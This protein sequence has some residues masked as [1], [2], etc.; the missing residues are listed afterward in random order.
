MLRVGKS[1][2]LRSYGGN[3]MKTPDGYYASPTPFRPIGSG[4]ADLIRRLERITAILEERNDPTRHFAKTYCHTNQAVLDEIHAGGFKDGAW[5]EMWG[6]AYAVKAV[7]AYEAMIEG[8]PTTHPWTAAFAASRNHPEMEVVRHFVIMLNAH[9]NHDLALGLLEV[10]TDSDFT[11]ESILAIREADHAHVNYCLLRLVASEHKAIIEAQGHQSLLDRIKGPLE[12]AATK[13]WVVEARAKTWVNTRL[14]AAER[15]KPDNGN[16]E[17]YKR[18]LGEVTAERV[19]HLR[20]SREIVL[21]LALEGFGVLID[22]A[23]AG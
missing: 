19:E 15:A 5:M 22:P 18:R 23:N 20:N 13:H 4:L 9:L 2:G 16:F 6:V 8:R 12:E 21:N 17:A 7:E 14:L 1:T 11:D 3:S 10:T